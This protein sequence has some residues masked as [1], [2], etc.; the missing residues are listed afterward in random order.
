MNEICKTCKYWNP[1]KFNDYD[2]ID[3]NCEKISDKVEAE[4]ITGWDGGYVKNFV[5]D[6][7][8][9][10]VLWEGKP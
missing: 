10:C 2:P 6:D 8:F 7:D 5:T 4:L 3:G 9:G 1:N